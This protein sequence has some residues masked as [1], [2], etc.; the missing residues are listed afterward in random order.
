MAPHDGST[1][2][3]FDY[4]ADAGTLTINGLGSHIALPKAVNGQELSSIADTP[5]SVTYDVLTVGS[6]SMTVTVEA[7]AGVFWSFRLKKD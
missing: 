6:D 3:S 2:G 7:G 1:T 5:E 4:D